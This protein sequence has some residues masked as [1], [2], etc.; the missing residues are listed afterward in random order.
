MRTTVRVFQRGAS[1]G[2]IC[3]N[4]A[5]GQVFQRERWRPVSFRNKDGTAAVGG[6][7]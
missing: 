4:L 1:V 6:R 2:P 3:A 5:R 7:R